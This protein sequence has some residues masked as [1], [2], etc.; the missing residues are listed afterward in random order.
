[1]DAEIMQPST[2]REF[3]GK[4]AVVSEHPLPKEHDG[5][6]TIQEQEGGNG[7]PKD[8]RFWLIIVGLLVA[9]FLS[10]LDLTGMYLLSA[11]C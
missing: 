6:E 1:M 3:E 11:E 9:T 8:I 10:A 5:A 7:T 4:S 2:Q